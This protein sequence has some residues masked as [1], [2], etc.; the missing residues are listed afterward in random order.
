MNIKYGGDKGGRVTKGTYL[1]CQ[2]TKLMMDILKSFVRIN[3]KVINK[4]EF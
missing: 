1:N 2:Q 3:D 4:L